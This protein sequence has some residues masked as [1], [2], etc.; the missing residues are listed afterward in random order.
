MKAINASRHQI[1]SFCDKEKK[2][3]VINKKVFPLIKGV[4][5]TLGVEDKEVEMIVVDSRTFNLVHY[6]L[7]STFPQSIDK[8]N[9]YLKK[10]PLRTL[11]NV[12]FKKLI[13]MV[14]YITLKKKHPWEGKILKRIK[15]LLRSILIV[16]L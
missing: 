13:R 9:K 6:K 5:N 8:L 14:T 15:N 3:L 4:K 11:K 12:S 10:F 2:Y 7:I 1:R 16:N